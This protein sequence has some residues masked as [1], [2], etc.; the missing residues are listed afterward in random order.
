MLLL[1]PGPVTTHDAVR[2][3]AACDYAPWDN[4]FRTLVE[5]VRTRVLRLAGGREGEHTALPLQGCGHFA[6]EAAC[7][8]FVAPDGRI[9]VPK[10]GQYADRL[11]RLAHE[12]GRVVVG[13]AVPDGARVDPDA[14]RAAL[15]ADPTLT[16]VALVYSETATGLIHDVPALAAL[17]GQE[18]RRVIV[19]AVSAFGALPLDL[20]TLPMID[21]VCFTTNKCIEGLPG[22]SFTIARIDRLEASVGQAQSWSFD[23]ADLHQHYR[24]MPGSHRYTPAA[25]AIAS[26]DV[27]LD[28]FD[29]EGGQPARLARYTAIMGRLYDG[30]VG[31]G[32]TPCLP[33]ALQGPIVVNVRAPADPAWRLQEFVDQLKR[34]GVLISN[35]YNTA[36]PSFRVGCIGAITPDDMGR[37]V[38]CM[39]QALDDMTVHRR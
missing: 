39:T 11:E 28:L 19:D 18:G 24:Q 8:T 25:G 27:A 17:A 7:R 1:I 30:V 29:A 16:H 32:L 2:A 5:R 20:A 34:R 26:F 13:L 33:F 38:E 31:L 14:L 36:E 6:L 15:R 3:A 4:E 22:A 10:T 23:L 12:A 21:S 37:A 35:F 9:L